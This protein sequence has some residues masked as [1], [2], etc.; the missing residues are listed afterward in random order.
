M[1]AQVNNAHAKGPQVKNAQVNTAHAK[2]IH[3]FMSS[4]VKNA[5]VNNADVKTNNKNPHKVFW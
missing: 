4:Q 2:K 5:H 3:K 1:N